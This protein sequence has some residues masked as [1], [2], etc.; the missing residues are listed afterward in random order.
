MFERLSE[1]LDG[2]LDA[3]SCSEIE[4]H[5]RE[6]IPCEACFK[7]LERTVALCRESEALPLPESFAHRLKVVVRSMAR[8]ETP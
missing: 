8:G 3:V 1:Y 6:C 5:V 2:E 4:R 7:T